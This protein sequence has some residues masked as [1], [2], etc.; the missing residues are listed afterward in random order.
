MGMSD[1][2]LAVIEQRNVDFYGDSLTAV[3]SDDGQIYV[4]LAQMCQALGID[5]QAQTRRIQ[6]LEILANGFKGVAKLATPGGIQRGYVLRV[7]LV[8]LWLSGIRT[9]AVS[10]DV[11]PKLERFQREAAKVLWEAFQSGRLTA[12]VDFDALLAQDS[13]EAQAYK[14]AQAVMQLARNQ[15]LLRAQLSDHEQRLEAIESHLGDPGR[16][17]TADQASQISQAVKAVALAFSKKSGR[18]EFGAIYGELYRKFGITGYKMLPA[19]RF[20]E[21][22]K[23]LTDWHEELTGALP[24]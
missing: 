15:L 20:D 13:P 19:R 10:D 5:I 8:P 4:A 9:S 7:D 1:K 11:R 12:D 17:V 18:N 24:F 2:A 21:A 22:M 14:M 3:R 6:R 23:F 16:Y